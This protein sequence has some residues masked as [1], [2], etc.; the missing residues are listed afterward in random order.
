MFDA[1]GEVVAGLDEDDPNNPATIADNVPWRCVEGFTASRDLCQEIES[2]SRSKNIAVYTTDFYFKAEP[3]TET[4]PMIRLTVP[5]FHF[6]FM[7]YA[8]LGMVKPSKSC[9]MC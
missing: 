7:G 3:K 8:H 6:G 4:S 1:I 5:R 9:A 2:D